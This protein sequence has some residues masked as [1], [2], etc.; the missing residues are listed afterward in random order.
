MAVVFAKDRQMHTRHQ[1]DLVNLDVSITIYN[2][3][4]LSNP[5]NP[6]IIYLPP[7]GI[8]LKSTHPPLPSYLLS[9]RTT[10]A[11]INYRWNAA[12]Q[13]TNPSSPK[14]LSSNPSYAHHPFP[15]PL[16][17]TLAGYNFL[18]SSFLPR[19]STSTSPTPTDSNRSGR[20]SLY[21]PTSPLPTQRPILIYGSFLGGTLATSLALTENFTSR[22]LPT[23]IIGL[24]TKDAVFDWTNIVTS[25][26]PLTSQDPPSEPEYRSHPV[27]K[28]NHPEAGW[29]SNILHSLK[30]QLFSSPASAF[31]SF[32]SPTLFF[33][34]SGLAIPQT[35]VTEEEPSFPSTSTSSSLSPSE[36]KDHWPSGQDDLSPTP[37]P[38]RESISSTLTTARDREAEA[39]VNLANRISQLHIS[40]PSRPSHLKFPPSTSPGLKIPFSLFMYTPS[41]S[42]SSS[43]SPPSKSKRKCKPKS[44]PPKKAHRKD[45]NADTD[46]ETTP[47]PASQAK[48]LASLMRRSVFLHEFAGRKVWD[49]EL[50]PEG[51][52]EARC[53][54]VALLREG[55]GER[56]GDGESAGDGDGKAGTDREAEIVGAWLDELLG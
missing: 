44:K 22:I 49:E 27:S 7:T 30:T 8:H 12:S 56:D 43:S 17:D 53:K 32:A 35:W 50:D 36:A 26:P 4:A 18:L 15:T 55:A 34:T 5:S 16:H 19:Y 31:D 14:P 42:P 39:Q 37:V 46:T 20:Q 54:T 52:S 6:L 10:L 11:S 2:T 29:H 25:P 40:L 48:T 41:P 23:K 45:T 21:A 33:R 1:A 9:P 47:T 24:I 28:Q 13:P 51:A 38:T 3:S